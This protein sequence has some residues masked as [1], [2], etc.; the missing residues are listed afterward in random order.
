[1]ANETCVS[2]Q[3]GRERPLSRAISCHPASSASRASVLCW[4]SSHLPPDKCP[5]CALGTPV[6]VPGVDGW[7]QGEPLNQPLSGESASLPSP[8]SPQGG[9]KGQGDPPRKDQ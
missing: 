7:G 1:M 3:M 4:G 6:P 8:P 5:P 2:W 9:A